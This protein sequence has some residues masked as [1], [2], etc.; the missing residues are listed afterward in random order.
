MPRQA[1]TLK[2]CPKGKIVNPSTGRCVKKKCPKGKML[3]IGTGRCVNKPIRKTRKPSKTN[4]STNVKKPGLKLRCPNGYIV[5][6]AYLREAYT[7]K[8]GTMVSR[9]LVP[10][11]CI[12]SQGLPGKTSNRYQ[13]KNKGIGPLKKGELSKHG[14]VKVKTMPVRKRRKALDGAIGEY[15]AM[16]VLKKIGAV[17][18]YQK[19]KSPET[20]RVFMDNM[21]WLRKKY[22]HQ[23]KSSWKDSNLFTP[24][25]I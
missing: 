18:T 21:R 19:N 9:K 6:N 4:K 11:K 13:G 1:K 2:K 3:N 10:A 20:S 5:R 16:K 24:L 15:G 25:K 12:K 8:N 7:R 17:K 23:F 14:Y 22:D